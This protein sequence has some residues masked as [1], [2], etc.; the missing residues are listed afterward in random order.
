MKGGSDGDH[1][2]PTVMLSG[3]HEASRRSDP[4]YSMVIFHEGFSLQKTDHPK[5]QIHLCR[6]LRVFRLI[7]VVFMD[8]NRGFSLSDTTVDS[9][10]ILRFCFSM[11]KAHFSQKL[12]ALWHCS[13]RVLLMTFFKMYIIL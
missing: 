9:S 10:E 12:R 4:I 1:V 11:L 8:K 3:N 6:R 2:E 7:H 13:D 5:A